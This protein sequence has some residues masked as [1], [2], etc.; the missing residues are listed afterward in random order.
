MA[1]LKTMPKVLNLGHCYIMKS[2]PLFIRDFFHRRREVRTAI[3]GS[4]GEI[5][6]NFG[7]RSA[8]V[9]MT[10]IIMGRYTCTVRSKI[11]LLVAIVGLVCL[12]ID[13]GFFLFM[14]LSVPVRFSFLLD[15]FCINTV[16]SFVKLSKSSA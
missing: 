2:F 7:F 14:G 4:L 1:A 15:I 8:E 6:E 10:P 5:I 16:N 12:R 3:F 11:T 13:L 9:N